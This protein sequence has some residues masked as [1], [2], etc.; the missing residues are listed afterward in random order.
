[1]LVGFGFPARFR[2]RFGFK[3]W[4]QW[5]LSGPRIGQGLD[6]AG[7]DGPRIGPKSNKRFFAKFKS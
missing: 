3:N 6:L 7:L 5:G 4:T 1:M 2:V